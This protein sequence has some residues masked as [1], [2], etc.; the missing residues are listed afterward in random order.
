MS[1][2]YNFPGLARRSA[3]FV[4]KMQ[5]IADDIHVD[6][7]WLLAVMQLES[8]ID[9]AA[10][11]PK[12]DATGLIQFMPET[13]QRLGTSV[14][15]LREMSD[16]E[17]LDWVHAFYR[18]WSGNLHSVGDVYLATFWPAAVSLPDDHVIS[19]AGEA[20]YDTNKVL[21]VDGDGQLTAGDVRE[22]G[23]RLLRRY[24]GTTYVAPTS[25]ATKNPRSSRFTAV[26]GV[27]V[28]GAVAA[29]TIYAVA[30]FSR[31]YAA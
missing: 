19:V 27:L 25:P 1:T 13:A 24:A 17:Q 10:R 26:V 3:A 20:V 11:N 9:P 23:A 8:G 5:S 29:G 30:H 22:T 14:A 7:N 4:A 28:F 15:A 31:R 6:P 18:R 16:D 2:L 12:S 21:D